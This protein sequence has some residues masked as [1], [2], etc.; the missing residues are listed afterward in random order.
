MQIKIV[1]SR[2]VDVVCQGSP[3][4]MGLAQ[5]IALQS[6]IRAARQDTLAK[7]EAFRL[8]QP[9]GLPYLTYR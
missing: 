7:L 2:V 1:P 3:T 9:R 6:K 5:G 8:Q 4:E